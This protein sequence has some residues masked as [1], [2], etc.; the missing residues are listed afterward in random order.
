MIWRV[1]PFDLDLDRPAVMGVL[2]TTPDSFSDGGLHDSLHAAVEHADRLVADGALIIDVGG[3]STRPG[4]DPV[5]AAVEIGR[6]IPVVAELAS[7]PVPI[8]IDT[9]KPEVM[10]SALASGASIVNDVNAFR[11][12]GAVDVVRDTDCGVV[13]V[14]MR[15]EP[16][17]MQHSPRY[18]DVVTDVIGFLRSRLDALVAAGIEPDRIA[19]D[20]GIG[21]GKTIEHNLELLHRLGDLVALGRPVV[22]GAS[23]KRFIGTIT[24]QPP[25]RRDA[26]SIG[27]A[28]ACA[29]RGA[30]VVRAHDVRGTV[31]ALSVM[32][33]IERGSFPSHERSP[34]ARPAGR[35]GRS[36][37]PATDGPGPRR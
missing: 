23:R 35:E 2:N 21:F 19:L 20:P 7:R 15:G 5:P 17:T 18:G 32:H 14:H 12:P 24:G 6:T 1:G 3:E 11:A 36:A 13:V 29:H 4:A 34:A 25:D 16:R 33:A 30:H 37:R 9:M 31:D 26:G 22:V 28:L 27:A 10:E 8:S